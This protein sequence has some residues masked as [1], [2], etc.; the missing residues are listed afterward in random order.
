MPP[1]KKTPL[2]LAG[3]PEQSTPIQQAIR[4]PGQPF[5]PNVMKTLG[6]TYKKENEKVIVSAANAKRN[7]SQVSQTS[8]EAIKEAK[9]SRRFSGDHAAYEDFMRNQVRKM[10]DATGE[11]I[12][13]DLKAAQEQVRFINAQYHS[14]SNVMRKDEF[15]KNLEACETRVVLSQ[16]NLAVLQGHRHQ[17]MGQLLDDMNNQFQLRK[18]ED[19]Q[20]IDLLIDRYQTPA[21]ATLSLFKA[22]DGKAQERF[23]KDVFKANDTIDRDEAWCCISGKYCEPDMVVAAHI[24]PYNVGEMNAVYLF[25]ESHPSDKNGHI[26]SARN[27]IPMRQDYEK[28]FDDGRMTLVPVSGTNDI[29]VVFFKALE[30]DPSEHARELHGRTLSFK[31]DFRPAHRYLYFHYAMTLLRRQRHK[32]PGWWRGFKEYGLH[33]VWATP[34]AY[35]RQS[36]MLV[37]ARN[38]GHLGPDEAKVFVSPGGSVKNVGS[39]R[40]EGPDDPQR[41][42]AILTSINIRPG[43]SHLGDPFVRERSG[44]DQVWALS[45]RKVSKEFETAAEEAHEADEEY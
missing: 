15:D 16:V 8:S 26:M 7:F 29:K 30:P 34:G 43:P 13:A 40:F 18:M 38:I 1:S 44:P 5:T 27:G 31:N 4:D 24:V 14:A 10:M 25:G 41:E 32:V 11:V 35:L 37:L 36:A 45:N 23:R 9:S 12:Q 21:N 42:H 20:R 19:A 17:M 33:K 22:R 39:S 3:S 2:K 6:A 28:M